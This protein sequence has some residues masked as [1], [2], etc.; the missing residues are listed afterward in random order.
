MLEVPYYISILFILLTFAVFA[1]WIL[2]VNRAAMHAHLLPTESMALA[3]RFTIGIALWLAATGVL[4]SIGFFMQTDAMPPKILLVAGP[5]LI[6]GAV[7]TYSNRAKNLLRALPI[8]FI[9]R[10]QSFRLVVE[11]IFYF[12]LIN[13]A[14]PALMTF[15]GR[16][17]DIFVG[18]TAIPVAMLAKRG[19]LSDAHLK[20]WNY[21][22]LMILTSVMVHGML[23]SPS[24][25]QQIQTVPVN[26]FML[27]FPFVWLIA[28]LVPSA[29]VG[30]LMSL[31]QL[32][33]KKETAIISVAT[34]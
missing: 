9:I 11:I 15:E 16:N 30:H 23:S 26:N 22:G 17:M 24:P 14:I 3:R 34:T 1:L 32:S 4:A 25:I 6:A 21:V 33:L 19:K 20:L 2:G 5:A 28:L 10:A 29:F 27:Q 7:L 12:L 13:G 18:L 8:T 31:R